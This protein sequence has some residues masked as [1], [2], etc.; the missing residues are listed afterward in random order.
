MVA[1]GDSHG[2]VT[3]QGLSAE[4]EFFVSGPTTSAWLEIL[5]PDRRGILIS[6]PSFHA[7][8][9]DDLLDHWLALARAHCETTTCIWADTA[10][11]DPANCGDCIDND[12]DGDPDSADLS[13]KHRRDFGCDG[14]GEHNHRWENSKDF[15]EL[16]DIEWCTAMNEAGLAWHSELYAR[17]MLASGLLNAIPLALAEYTDLAV[18][19]DVATIRYRFAACVFADSTEL[20]ESCVDDDANCPPDYRMGGVGHL[21]VPGSENADAYF[22]SMWEE[23]DVAVAKAEALGVSPKPVA[24]LSGVYSGELTGATVGLAA[25]IGNLALFHPTL[26]PDPKRVGACTVKASYFTYVTLGHELGH[27]L[28]L[29]HTAEDPG[30]GKFGFMKSTSP[31][32][33]AVLGPSLESTDGYGFMSQWALWVNRIGDKGTPRPN[34]F[35]HAGC[36]NDSDCPSQLD[37]WNAGPNGVCF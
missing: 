19:A 21:I 33:Y 5:P 24:M 9:F 20:A 27:L 35:A 10:E 34:A 16:P 4:Q 36:E 7:T 2:G 22:R 29:S 14:F 23:F 26:P 30:S 8:D 25:S 12:A 18:P 32:P 6:K 13:C 15:A 3:I 37:C 17:A 31:P 28:G 11:I 1:F